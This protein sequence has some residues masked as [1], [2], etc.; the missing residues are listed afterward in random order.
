ML[1]NKARKKL[2]K[3]KAR[4]ESMGNR[5][6]AAHKMLAQNPVEGVTPRKRKDASKE[7]LDDGE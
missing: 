6:S 1:S 4:A 3:A 5:D 2:E 7:K